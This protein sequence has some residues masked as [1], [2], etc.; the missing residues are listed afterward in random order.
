MAVTP[1]A[2]F[3]QLTMSGTVEG[4]SLGGPGP[5]GRTQGGIATGQRS[6]LRYETQ[7]ARREKRKYWLITPSIMHSDDCPKIKT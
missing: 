7:S 1:L 3:N 6:P 4:Q 2:D 5:S